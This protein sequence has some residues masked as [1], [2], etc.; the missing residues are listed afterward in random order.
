MIPGIAHARI[1]VLKNI[2]VKMMGFGLGKLGD[3][4]G[5]FL[6]YFRFLW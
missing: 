2:K 4:L 6:I 5:L 3:G 1:L